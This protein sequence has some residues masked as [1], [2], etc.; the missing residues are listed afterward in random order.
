MA[1]GTD[2]ELI[3][4]DALGDPA[5]VAVGTS[6]HVLTSGGAGVAP[7]FQAAAGEFKNFQSYKYTGIVA[8]SLTTSETN[9]WS[10]T[11]NRTSPTSDIYINSMTPAFELPNGVWIGNAMVINGFKTSR[12]MCNA[13]PATDTTMIGFNSVIKASEIGTTTGNITISHMFNWGGSNAA[14]KPWSYLN[15]AGGSGGPRDPRI[16]S[17]L[18]TEGQMVIWEIM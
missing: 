14:V 5:K 1:G 11:F 10:V 18:E 6:G 8:F 4:Y 12:G 3:T 7:T 15:F 9:W 2:G 13:R 16:S 17:S